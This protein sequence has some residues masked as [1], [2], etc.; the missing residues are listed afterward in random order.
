M[1][2]EMTA[3]MPR[4]TE[5]VLFI[6]NEAKGLGFTVTQYDVVKSLFLADEEHLN[7]YGRPI[8]FDNYVA[9]EHGPVPDRSYDLLKEDAEVG[10]RLPWV[11]RPAPELGNGCFSFERPARDADEDVL[12]PSDMKALRKALKTV[13]A[14]GF[15]GVRKLTHDHPAYKEAWRDEPFRRSFPMDYSKL[16]HAPNPSRAEELA[17]LS[18][19]L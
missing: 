9:M 18:N 3:N 15:K 2:Q 19:H 6:I 13:K 11:R 17:F 10:G 5:A 12:S 16:F 8:T 7:C 1:A 4:I 14:L